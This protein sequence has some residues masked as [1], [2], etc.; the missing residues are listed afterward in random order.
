MN[1][2]IEEWIHERADER[3]RVDECG[4]MDRRSDG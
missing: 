2:W 3:M 4:W 1:G